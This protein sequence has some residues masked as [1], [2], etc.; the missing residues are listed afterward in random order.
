MITAWRAS[1]P[2]VL[3]GEVIPAR[4]TWVVLPRIWIWERGRGGI[5][6]WPENAIISM[7]DELGLPLFAGL[8]IPDSPGWNN[9]CMSGVRLPSGTVHVV[10]EKRGSCVSVMHVCHLCAFQVSVV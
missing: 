8:G 1:Y 4:Q 10:K 6:I 3:V 9:V 7:H 2:I 5:I